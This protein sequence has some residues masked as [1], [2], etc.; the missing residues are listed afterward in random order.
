MTEK[1]PDVAYS[2]QAS[3]VKSIIAGGVSIGLG[4]VWV[5]WSI[6]LS[7]YREG[8]PA[9]LVFQIVGYLIF[10]PAELILSSNYIDELWK[11]FN[12]YLLFLIINA[13]PWSILFFTLYTGY[14]KYIKFRIRKKK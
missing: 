9:L 4:F 10:L 7:G 6:G 13:I 2:I 3:I 14:H 11:S 5:F 8:A 12:G 1:K